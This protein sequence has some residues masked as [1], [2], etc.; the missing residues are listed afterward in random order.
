[1]LI[2][3]QN[4]YAHCTQRHTGRHE[5]QSR[6]TDQQSKKTSGIMN[7]VTMGNIEVASGKFNV[8]SHNSYNKIMYRN[9]SINSWFNL[10]K[11]TYRELEY[12]CTALEY[13]CYNVLGNRLIPCLS[14]HH[15]SVSAL[16]K[17]VSK[18]VFSTLCN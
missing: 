13:I 12:I 9:K 14:S 17:M 16:L 3:Q 10:S 5:V 7:T 18:V 15:Q 4:L 2:H 8:D 1:M 6:E 11:K